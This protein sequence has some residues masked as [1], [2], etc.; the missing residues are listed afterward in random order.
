MGTSEH[1]ADTV[2]QGGESFLRRVPAWA[3][4]PLEL[5]RCEGC[6][7]LVLEDPAASRSNGCS[8]RDA[9]FP[10]KPQGTG[11]GLIPDRHTA[12]RR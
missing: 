2:R 6:P 9:F 8:G 12:R 4:R 1:V 10:T 5:S 11:M 7:V 3:V